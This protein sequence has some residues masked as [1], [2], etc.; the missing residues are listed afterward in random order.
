MSSLN[1]RYAIV[2]GAGKG[3][4]AA[5]ATRLLKDGVA[6]VALLDYDGAMVAETAARL[7]ATGAYTMAVTL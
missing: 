4:G 3:I 7:D 6:G 1:G 5:I 2:T